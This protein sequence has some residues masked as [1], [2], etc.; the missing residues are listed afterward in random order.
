M[1]V[2]GELAGL[3]V[4][5]GEE[6]KRRRRALVERMVAR[7]LELAKGWDGNSTTTMGVGVYTIEADDVVVFE[8]WNGSV[9][10]G[11]DV[12]TS[13][14]GSFFLKIARQHTTCMMH[15]EECTC[16]GVMAVT[17]LPYSN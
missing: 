1:D 6:G 15:D 4:E 12:P 11:W 2:R 3:M 7:V 16:G 14:T 5:V 8:R 13:D 10:E 9:F 17:F